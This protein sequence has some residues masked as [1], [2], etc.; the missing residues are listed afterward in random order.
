M[1]L[2]RALGLFTLACMVSCG[3]DEPPARS[4]ILVTVDTLRADH[5][6]C[7][8]Y[9]RA[10][11][12]RLDAFV[13]RG[14]RF[15]YAFS[16]SP[17]TAPSHVSILTGLYPSFHPIG[18]ENSRFQ[19]GPGFTTLAEACK[20]AGLATAAIVS[21][22]V[23]SRRTGLAQ[24]FDVYDDRFPDA[25]GERAAREKTAQRTARSAVRMLERFEGERFFLWI[26][27]QDPHGPYSPPAQYAETFRGSSA[28]GDTARVLDVGATH[29]G[30][31]ELPRY[32]VVDEERRLAEYIRRYDAEIRYL[33]DMLGTVFDALDDLGLARETL[34]AL[35]AD[36]GEAFGEDGYFCAH[37]HGIGV[38]QTR[39]PLAFV[40][41]EVRA[42]GVLEGGVSNLDVFAT[43]LD[44]LGLEAQ[45][46]QSV[47]LMPELRDGRE[48][49]RGGY[50][51]S[52]TQRAA[53]GAGWYVRSDSRPL[54]DT[55]FWEE[56]NP[57]TKAPYLPLGEMKLDWLKADGAHDSQGARLAA[58]ELR[59]TLERFHGK[60]EGYRGRIEKAR[61]GERELTDEE[62]EQ[63]RALGYVD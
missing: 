8:G 42:G 14:T 15:E 59:G 45:H 1:S 41:P 25:E 21:N 5:L 60:A 55:A 11:S 38:D 9:G 58:E 23:L 52:V 50:A 19:L 54:S 63:M 10:T 36:H 12:P 49:T 29:A 28:E 46:Q 48:P 53:F 30:H 51:E 3:S 24:G 13:E 6:S 56:R 34:V 43:A 22:P 40:G 2:A 33:D 26:H 16:T 7:Y 47:S 31:G 44:A 20:S 57:Y 62:R 17:R 39:V 35:T 27:F 18:H 4:L 61:S 32:Q 37:G